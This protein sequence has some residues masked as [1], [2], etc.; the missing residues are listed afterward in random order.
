MLIRFVSSTCISTEEKLF[1]HALPILKIS[2]YSGG[3]LQPLSPAATTQWVVQNKESSGKRQ[4]GAR[5]E[6]FVLLGILGFGNF[7]LITFLLKPLHLTSQ[8]LNLLGHV[9]SIKL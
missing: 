8:T 4:V 7:I 2:R 5:Q 1:K 9:F 6:G 3:G